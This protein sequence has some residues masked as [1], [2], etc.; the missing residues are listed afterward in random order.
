MLLRPAAF[1]ICEERKSRGKAAMPAIPNSDPGQQ[2][3]YQEMVRRI[4]KLVHKHVPS[5]CTLLVASRG[6]PAL[7]KFSRRTGWHFPRNAAGKYAGYYPASSTSAIA[8]L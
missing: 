5:G 6:D 8:H 1:L 3:R 4:R 2:A 7:L